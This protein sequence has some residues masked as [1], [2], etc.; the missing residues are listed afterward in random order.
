MVRIDGTQ[1]VWAFHADLCSEFF[2][3]HGSDNLSERVLQGDALFNCSQEELRGE[4]RIL[5]ILR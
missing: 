4:F 3:S 1:Q 5:Q 2:D